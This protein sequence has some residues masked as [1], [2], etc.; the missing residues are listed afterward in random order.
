MA[1]TIDAY[2]KRHVAVV[3]LPGA[4]LG[5]NMEDYVIMVS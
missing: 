3:D 2:E 5:A 1:D 4:F